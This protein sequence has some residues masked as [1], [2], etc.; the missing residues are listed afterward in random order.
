MK[1]TKEVACAMSLIIGSITNDA[2]SGGHTLVQVLQ[3]ETVCS[4]LKD[5]NDC[6]EDMKTDGRRQQLLEVTWMLYLYYK[7]CVRYSEKKLLI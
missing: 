4:Y 5:N 7:E 3:A 1:K 2:I 6:A